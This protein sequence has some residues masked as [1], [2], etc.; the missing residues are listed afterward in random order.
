MDNRELRALVYMAPSPIHGKGLFARRRIDQGDYIGTY[1][2]P[3]AKRNGSHV[4][5]VF[6]EGQEPVGRRGLNLLRYLNHDDAPLA[7]F[8]GFDLYALRTIEP[9]EE[10]TINYNGVGEDT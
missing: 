1:E 3:D 6:E 9:D 4:L 10:I 8:D 5:W 7:E 2:G